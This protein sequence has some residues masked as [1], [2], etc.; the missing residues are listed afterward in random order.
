MNNTLKKI[1]LFAPM[2]A[3]IAILAAGAA[4]AQD[5]PAAS[6]AAASGSVA[7]VNGKPIPKAR[8][9]MLVAG[10][11]MQGLPDTPE[12]R[13]AVLEELI[14]GEVLMQEATKKGFDKKA[15]VQLQVEV[16]RQRV[17][18]GA[19]LQDYVKK[20]PITDAAIK[21]DYD[22]V[23]ARLGEKEYKIRHILVKTEE[24]AVAI[25]DKMN[26]GEKIDTLASA[27][28]DPGSKERGGDLGWSS[29]A[30]FVKPFADAV[31]QLQ[32]GTYT[33]TPVK[34]DFGY[35]VILVEEVRDLKIA[36]LEEARQQIANRLTQ[37]MVEKHMLELR[38][39][40]KVT[41]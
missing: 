5:K 17:V 32:P 23:K 36:S 39:K 41:P 7:T 38:S 20:N 18:V 22:A 12:L 14:R 4:N 3:T 13:K 6:P 40:A 8:V 35:H 15:D 27:S 16:A 10:Q 19:Y 29:P 28:L 11:M 37:K 34:T 24:E 2:L 1:Q 33:K 25:I 26:Q 9:E 30:A 31:V 21:A